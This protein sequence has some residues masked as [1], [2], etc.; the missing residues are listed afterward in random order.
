M[1]QQTDGGEESLGK[2][3]LLLLDAARLGNVE[4]VREAIRAGAKP[5]DMGHIKKWARVTPWLMEPPLSIAAWNGRLDCVEELAKLGD[6]ALSFSDGHATALGR[7]AR[8]GHISCAKA[9][10]P[11][12]VA[13]GGEF[14]S[15]A[16]H[17]IL[18]AENVGLLEHAIAIAGASH[19]FKGETLL[20]AASRQGDVKMMEACLVDGSDID[21]ASTSG[22]TALSIAADACHEDACRMLVARG[23]SPS[24]VDLWGNTPLMRVA[25]SSSAAHGGIGALVALLPSSNPDSANNIGETALMIAIS[26][27][28]QAFVEAL[29]PIS[30]LGILD[31]DGLSALDHAEDLGPGEISD[32]VSGFARAMAESHE[33]GRLIGAAQVQKHFRL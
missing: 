14:L 1:A 30:S 16:M 7:A 26:N 4:Q 15:K 3:W 25:G 10:L 5:A 32:M 11:L 22:E 29:L 28:A 20:M 33:M 2:A 23:A 19:R 27:H 6:P 24:S 8:K 17:D 21:E 9:L 12:Y 13:A 18:E 31:L